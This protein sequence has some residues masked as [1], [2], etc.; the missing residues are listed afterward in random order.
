MKGAKMALIRPMR[1]KRRRRLRKKGV[2][3]ERQRRKRTNARLDQLALVSLAQ[4]RPPH[5]PVAPE[6]EPKQTKAQVP[7]ER[8]RE[9]ALA[10]ALLP[11][12]APDRAPQGSGQRER[13]VE[14]VLVEQRNEVVLL[15]HDPV[16]DVVCVESLCCGTWVRARGKRRRVGRAQGGKAGDDC[17]PWN[18]LDVALR[19]EGPSVSA[20]GTRQATGIPRAPRAARC[21]TRASPTACVRPSQ[22]APRA[23]RRRQRR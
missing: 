5:L 20:F 23:K 11:R 19:T 14:Q 3:G 7:L 8:L 1:M 17:V 13:D 9:H 16:R 10:K 22:S 18:S 2:S 15:A 4:E 12:Q 6:Q 21:R